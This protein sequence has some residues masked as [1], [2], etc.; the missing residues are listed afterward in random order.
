MS[1]ATARLVANRAVLTEPELVAVKGRQE[2]I[3]VRRLMAF[4]PG[5]PSASDTTLTGRA[6]ELAVLA[7]LLDRCAS[8]GRVARVVGPPGIGKTR[9]LEELIGLAAA[10]SLPVYLSYCESHTRTVPFSAARSLFRALF[11]LGA[12]PAQ[13]ARLRV[14][15]E[16][17]DA[18][19]GDLLL[20]EDLLGIGEPGSALPEVSA[21]ALRRRLGSLVTTVM[22]QRPPAL[23]VMEDVHWI[24]EAS[25]S[26]LALVAEALPQTRSL[27]VVT[28]RPEYR[29]ALT[30]VAAGEAVVL[31]PLADSEVTA[32]T[33]QL[34]GSD[35]SVSGIA[36]RIV[37]TAGG[38]PL[39]VTELVRDLA[40]R[41]VLSGRRGRYRSTG[42]DTALS[43]PAT[44]RATI[45]ARVDR[46]P[47]SVKS[48][49][50]AAAVIGI[51][52]DRDLLRSVVPDDARLASALEELREG[53]FVD[54]VSPTSPTEFTFRH[55]LIR[56]VAYESQL[57]TVR[58]DAHRRVAAALQ[59]T[60][61]ADPDPHAALIAEHLHAAG[62]LRSAF[63]W[64]MRAGRWLRS[65][66][67]RAARESWRSAR[68]AAEALDGDPQRSQLLTAA[69]TQLCGQS[70]RTGG[71]LE[72]SGLETLRELSTATGD[73]RSLA[74]GMAG[75][76]MALSGQ[77]RHREALALIPELTR[78]LRALGDPGLSYALL[79]AVAY[80]LS[81]VGR[82][83][84]ALAIAQDVIDLSDIEPRGDLLFGSPLATAT[85]MRGLYRLCLGIPGWRADSDAAIEL[86]R[87]LD[88]ASRVSAVLYKYILSV[89][90]GARRVDEVALDES[91]EALR[92]AEQAGDEFTLTTAQV[93]RGL[94]LA[95]GNV[96][97]D[98]A[99]ELLSTARDACNRHGFTMNALA[100]AGPALARSMA[101]RGDLSG[102]INNVRGS[103]SDM[104]AAGEV[105]SMGVAT[106]ILVESLV[107]RGSAGDLA[108]AT[109]AV[110]Q[111]SSAT[112]ASGL[113]LYRVPML[114]LRALLAE[115]VGDDDGRHTYLDRARAAAATSD[116][117]LPQTAT[118]IFP[119]LL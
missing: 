95:Y 87:N 36:G 51:R 58:R 28:H 81:E 12:V 82:L 71:D 65:R 69:L 6:D 5:P 113:A 114:R 100:L 42:Q 49:L 11:T 37:E 115:A 23:H 85:R 13:Q 101:Q 31:K 3:A 19:P 32:L 107:K 66:D 52:F 94:V 7:A 25:E 61:H 34:L 29:G 33:T 20:L 83:R 104:R 30:T 92:L 79:P 47:S 63:D 102:A 110:D 80:S 74:T 72:Q 112:A 84:E 1:A 8:Q 76:V 44:V 68:A 97:T 45:G 41:G 48:V 40:E 108:E 78:L 105:L 39:F 10:R 24:D 14:R 77:H 50:Y 109:A 118:E 90:V 67:Q 55:P 86:S 62:E 93:A 18:D 35:A 53:E 4:V 73:R 75:M 9:L 46:L 98:E 116:Y 56:A 59:Q 43:V 27:F 111:L 2:P 38:N 88:P 99:T 91:A 70:W 60:H 89:P 57:K 54:R 16:L 64:H 96:P 22:L 15:A 117:E 26:L 17:V 21:D 106:S 119:S 103:I